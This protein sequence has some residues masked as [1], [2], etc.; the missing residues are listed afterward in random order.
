MLLS[1]FSLLSFP[2]FSVALLILGVDSVSM[3]LSPSQATLMESRESCA[4]LER[5]YVHLATQLL[6]QLQSRRVAEA[7]Q[8]AETIRVLCERGTPLSTHASLSEPPSHDAVRMGA[9]LF[10][11]SP[12]ALLLSM[13]NELQSTASRS[14]KQ[15]S[16]PLQQPPSLPSSEFGADS[17]ASAAARSG[18]GAASTSR[19]TSDT[20]TTAT[21][22]TPSLSSTLSH[23]SAA[24]NISS[25]SS[26][27]E[28][29]GR[30]APSSQPFLLLAEALTTWCQMSPSAKLHESET[31]ANRIAGQSKKTDICSPVAARV[32]SCPSPPVTTWPSHRPQSV[33]TTQS[34][35]GAEEGKGKAA[36]AAVLDADAVAAEAWERMQQQVAKE[37]ER[38]AVV[39][40]HR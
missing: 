17:D 30:H 22:D 37:M 21:P 1:R 25:P 34:R 18:D 10:H 23:S 11:G 20:S 26:L 9:K 3:S 31:G 33:N 36:S 8:T 12:A 29:A 35:D 38:L 40:K 13:R 15:L 28:S 19:G 2:F 6:L 4:V 24:E 7:L 39:R 27:A 16:P 5:S 14:P 32:P